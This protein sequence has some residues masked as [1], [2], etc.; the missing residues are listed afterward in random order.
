[1]LMPRSAGAATLPPT[2]SVLSVSTSPPPAGA[3]AAYDPDLNT[4]V[5]FGGTTAS[6]AYSDVTWLWNGASWAA[7]NT[8]THP[9][10]ARADASLAWDSAHRQLILFGGRS[11]DGT[12]L[13]DTWAWNGTTWFP[14]TSG[15]SVAPPPRFGATMGTDSTGELVLFGGTGQR[16]AAS[17]QSATQPA[18]QSS[19]SG[20]SA[21]AGSGAVTLGDTW[22]W[23]G[24]AWEQ[25]RPPASPPARTDAASAFDP[26]KGQL[27][28]FGGSAIPLG[29]GAAPVLLG[30]TWTWDG[31][32]W[33]AQTPTARPAPRAGSV[34][35][36]D[37]S[38]AEP[39]LFGG[40][41]AS[42]ALS[43]TWIWSGSDW[44]PLGAGG[45][46]PARADGAAADDIAAHQLVVFGGLAA[47]GAVEDTTMV[48]TPAPPVTIGTGSTASAT[49][50]N[51]TTSSSGIV[52]STSPSPAQPGA[53]SGGKP[54]PPA[55][56]GGVGSAREGSTPVAAAPLLATAH[57]V[58]QGN[59]VTLTGSG[60]SPA[61]RVTIRFYSGHAPPEI[62]GTAIANAL[63]RFSATVA[64]P[65][66]ASQGEHR[67]EA[68][69]KNGVGRLTALWT[70][71][72]VLALPGRG[73][74]TTLRTVLMTLIA[75]AIPAL[76]WFGLGWRS[77]RRAGAR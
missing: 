30:D 70:P 57:T 23:D 49:G 19:S 46:A 31:T 5:A 59:L 77:R 47:G 62:V 43:D 41:G 40:L 4:V 29:T 32:S 75:L 18:P 51:P 3:A 69:G 8:G 7:A 21:G 36:L 72:R 1:M 48:L 26:S 17:Q 44:A 22:T 10:A 9:P 6:G 35:A 76:T 42:G 13:N 58:Y 45:S 61:A 60:F 11:A 64:V 74:D 39:V 55:P 54:T 68:S 63:G 65:A 33:A 24:S 34:M 14:I 15:S 20:T 71:V 67:F 53:F 28:L 52:S 16:S 37:D 25:Q 27:L 12:L 73:S 50:G 2:W 66:D 38:L 56:T